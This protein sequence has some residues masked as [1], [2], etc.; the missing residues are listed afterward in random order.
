LAS[1]KERE[2]VFSIIGESLLLYKTNRED[3]QKHQSY[4]DFN[5]NICLESVSLLSEALKIIESDIIMIAS[6]E[7]QSLSVAFLSP[8]CSIHPLSC[9]TWLLIMGLFIF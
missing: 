3:K 1:N 9:A 2:E 7:S 5:S 8:N 4:L 6:E